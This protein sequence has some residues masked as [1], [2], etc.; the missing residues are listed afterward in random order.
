MGTPLISTI[1]SPGL[2]GLA[3]RLRGSLSRAERR[4]ETV[5]EGWEREGRWRQEQGG[6]EGGHRD[7]G[8]EEEGRW[9]QEQGGE[10]GGD[11][12]GGKGERRKMEIGQ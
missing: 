4:E 10:E 11:R 12:D 6:E 8:K 7:K 5:T 9:R 1:S 3:T 2:R